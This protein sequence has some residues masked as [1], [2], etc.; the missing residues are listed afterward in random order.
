MRLRT[1]KQ[2]VNGVL[3]LDKPSQLSS[4]SALQR[5]RHKFA[6]AKAGHTGT[7]DPLATGL[8][9]ICLGEA[10]KFSSFLLEADKRYIATLAFGK[11]T[12][13]GDLEGECV[14]ERPVNINLSQLTQVLASFIGDIWQVPPLYSA[15]KF[16]GKA[17]YQYA[18]EGIDI[19]RKPRKISIYGIKLVSF[20]NDTAV[21]DV[22]CSKGTY[23]RTLA[24]DIGEALG[25]GAHLAALRRT[26]T[27]GLDIAR[28]LPLEEVLSS[29]SQ[30]CQA[31]LLPVDA[32]VSALPAVS[33]SEESYI[34]FCHG[35]AVQIFEKHDIITNHRRVYRAEG[36]KFLGVALLK[37]TTMLCPLRLMASNPLEPN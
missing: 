27:A 33:L 29:T 11:V 9:P 24:Q 28:A 32:L 14:Q 34:K 18:R 3:L 36:H 16:Q 20:A 2:Q 19:E 26:R 23:L 35:Q 25:C 10:T 1:V 15:L 37:D 13:T 4:N 30:Q 17:L 5:V 12:T 21:I 7:L 8:L 22:H 31:A 6:A